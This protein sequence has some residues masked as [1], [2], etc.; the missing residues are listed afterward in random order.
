[1]QWEYCVL[2]PWVHRR[3]RLSVRY[4]ETWCVKGGRQWPDLESALEELGA[5]GWELVFPL[6][7]IFALGSASVVLLLRR[8]KE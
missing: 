5:A 7:G 8:P 4:T 1:M 2:K 6:H 3:G